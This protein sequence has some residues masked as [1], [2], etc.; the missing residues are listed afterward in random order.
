MDT[1]ISGYA[2]VK[3]RVHEYGF[4]YFV[5]DS[6]ERLVRTVRDSVVFVFC[7]FSIHA[8]SRFEVVDVL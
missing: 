8:Y 5:M 6:H 1:W 3:V 7:F 4:K 2:T